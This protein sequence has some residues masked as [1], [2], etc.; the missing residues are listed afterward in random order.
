MN[1]S[2]TKEQ[3]NNLKQ[4]S[5]SR[6]ATE[7]N[8]LDL[9][10]DA[11]F[12]SVNPAF[13]KP[14]LEHCIVV[15]LLENEIL[16][17]QGEENHY[18]YIL[19][20]GELRAFLGDLNQKKNSQ[21]KGFPILAGEHIGEMSIIEN[22]PVS[23]NVIA[24]ESSELLVISEDIFWQELLT[25]P[26][27]SKNLLQGLSKRM[28]QRDEIALKNLEESL[29]FE[30]IKKDLAAA[31]QIQFNILP[32]DPI[33]FPNHPQVDIAATITPARE[34][35]GDFYDA[36]PLDERHICVAVGDVSGKGIPA[37]L[38]MIRAVTL[39]RISIST[40]N[41]LGEIVEDI[42]RHLCERNDDC[43]FVT[44]FIGILDVISGEL[45]YVNGGHNPPFFAR[46][47]QYFAPLSSKAGMLLGVYDS[48]RYQTNTLSFAK[49]DVLILYTDGVTEAEN[50]AQSLFSAERT[51][52]VLNTLE[53][54]SNAQSAITVLEKAISD[55][56]S[57]AAQSDDIT[58]LVLRYQA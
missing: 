21:E 15:T 8:Y 53:K 43:M 57:T 14:L 56:C 45:T 54:G 51:Q 25:I 18:F 1:Q 47:G 28:R 46:N 24:V 36:F 50:Y 7:L 35:G 2:N 52:E 44:L 27:I 10:K 4:W 9:A 34:V 3:Q 16:V 30:Q 11:L 22:K 5:S 33:I 6:P 48:A 32:S 39:I 42:N 41:P 23:A 13:L 17:S 40:L 31:S 37:A 58:I 19:L 20:S 29:K 55:F 38:F 12:E 49:D 26:G